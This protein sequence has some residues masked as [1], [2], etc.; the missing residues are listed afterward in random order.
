LD[1]KRFY[2][3]IRVSLFRGSLTQAEVDNINIILSYWDQ[4]YTNN[5]KQQLA[6]VLATVLG[7]VGHRGEMGPV[8]ETYATSDA[9]ARYRLRHKK[10][11][12]SVPPYGHAYYGRGYVQ[13]TWRYNY[14]SQEARTGFPLVQYPDLALRTDVAV[15]VLVNGM[16]TGAFNRYGHGLAH[17]VNETHVDYVAAR[18]TV[19][20][21]D[22]AVE[23]A[24]YAHKFWDAIEYASIE[25]AERETI[26]MAFDESLEIQ[27]ESARLE[28]ALLLPSLEH[29]QA[30]HEDAAHEDRK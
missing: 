24:G 14:E 8:R 7:E 30:Q 1:H 15:D 13:L 18:Y 2:D 19:N 9:Q 26:A 25:V 4:S 22:R 21:Q 23:I 28:N 20:V 3:R 17:Y 10:Y 12:Q 5:P 29:L 11:A 16:M 27:V 6:Y